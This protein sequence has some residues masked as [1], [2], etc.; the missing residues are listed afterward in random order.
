MIRLAFLNAFKAGCS[1]I[2]TVWVSVLSLTKALWGSYCFC[3]NFIGKRTKKQIKSIVQGMPTM[4]LQSWDPYQGHLTPRPLLLITCLPLAPSWSS[5]SM[6]S[7]RKIPVLWLKPLEVR[8]C[9]Y[10]HTVRW[11]RE[12]F[13]LILSTMSW[14]I[15][16]PV[17]IALR[18]IYKITR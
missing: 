9:V 3:N 5:L 16:I 15:Q 11:P 13:D 8:R 4:T 12:N 1:K 17:L 7:L 14:S 10:A 2:N 18:S 6:E